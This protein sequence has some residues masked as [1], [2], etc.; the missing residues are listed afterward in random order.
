MDPTAVRSVAGSALPASDLPVW[1]EATVVSLPAD[2][3]PAKTAPPGRKYPELP[4]QS[5]AVSALARESTRRP[6]I[7]RWA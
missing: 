3:A 5:T 4:V 6:P 7:V 1:V 2:L